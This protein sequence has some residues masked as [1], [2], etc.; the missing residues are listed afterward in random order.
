MSSWV[1]VGRINEIAEHTCKIA[2]VNG[3]T[4]AIFNLNDEF[5]TIEDRCPH[6]QLP[7]ADGLVE[8]DDITCPFHGARFCIKTGQVLSPPACEDLTTWE[9]RIVDGE[10]QVKPR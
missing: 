9:T 5:Y 2:E 4:I 10:I 6:Q 1:A 3:V 8:G 7:I